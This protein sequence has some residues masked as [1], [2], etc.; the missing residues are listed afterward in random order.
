MEVKEEKQLHKLQTHSADTHWSS[1]GCHS[2]PKFNNS[3]FI[4]SYAEEEEDE[5]DDEKK[6]D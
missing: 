2:V 1:Y 4:R 3:I 6:S 5:D